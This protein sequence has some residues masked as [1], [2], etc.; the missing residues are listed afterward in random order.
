MLILASLTKLNGFLYYGPIVLMMIGENYKNKE[1]WMRAV[2]GAAIYSVAVGWWWGINGHNIYEYLTGLAGS[3]EKLTDPMN[4]LDWRTWIHYFRLFLVTQVG[5]VTALVFLIFGKKENKKLIWWTVL[6]YVIFTIIKNKDFRFTMP[7][8]AVVA[9]WLGSILPSGV[10]Q[11][12][13]GDPPLTSRVRQVLV[14]F[15][16]LWMGVNY[17]ENSFN[18]PWKKPMIV[19]TPTFLLGDINWINFSEYPVREFRREVWPQKEIMSQIED[20]KGRSV[21]VAMLMNQAELNDNNLMLEMEMEN[22]HSI[23]IHGIY[24]WGEMDFDYIV[25]PDLNTQS[26]PFYDVMLTARTEAIRQVWNNID[27]YQIVGEYNLPR[28]GKVYLLTTKNP[29]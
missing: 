23:E 5:P 8:L 22:R 15:L 4:L 26:A 18:W 20:G 9:V 27:Q 14:G 19:S 6:T 10:D 12:L 21:M 17:V 29:Q 24:Q 16:L 2:I 28:G 3:G 13:T 11:G 1:F 7:I 25:V